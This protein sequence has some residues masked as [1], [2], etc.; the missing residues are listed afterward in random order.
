LGRDT[1]V[2]LRDLGTI[3][4][5]EPPRYR[6]VHFIVDVRYRT[7]APLSHRALVRALSVRI[8]ILL[9][10]RSRLP[11]AGARTSRCSA[12]LRSINSFARSSSTALG[13][14]SCKSTKKRPP[15][16]TSSTATRSFLEPYTAS[17]NAWHSAVTVVTSEL[18]RAGVAQTGLDGSTPSGTRSSPIGTSPNAIAGAPGDGHGFRWRCCAAGK[19]VPPILRGTAAADGNTPHMHVRSIH[20]PRV[21]LI[22]HDGRKQD[23]VEWARYNREALLRCRLCAT[24]TTG[25]LVL[26]ATGLP[27]EL[28]LSGPLGGDAQVGAAIVEGRLDLVVFFWDPLS[29]QAHDVDVKA[30]L[31]LAVLYNVPIACNR[32]TADYLITSQLFF[33]GEHRD[34]RVPIPG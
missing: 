16:A 22:A 28:L 33:D 10:I 4:R 1:D 19:N 30:L 29:T 6:Y 12:V 11:R 3:R 13:S 17:E 23:L 27:I 8:A 5:F 18:Q 20:E 34:R 24:G 31:R 7:N 2:L 9:A 15:A 26:E 21:A 25:S 32:A 14:A